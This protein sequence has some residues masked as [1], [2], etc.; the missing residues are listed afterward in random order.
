MDIQ[1][2]ATIASPIISAIAIIVALYIS[3]KTSKELREQNRTIRCASEAEIKQIRILAHTLI[4]AQI[5]SLESANVNNASKKNEIYES[6]SLALEK[7]KQIEDYTIDGDN[8]T[9]EQINR[10]F[11]EMAEIQIF[12]VKVQNDL[13]GILN[14]ANAISKALNALKKPIDA[15][16]EN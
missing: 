3:E 2:I 16:C 4:I 7:I 12:L 10:H 5:Y 11:A 1:T 6:I 8:I 15:F 13:A 9:V 14:E